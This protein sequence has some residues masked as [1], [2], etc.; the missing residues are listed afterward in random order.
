MDT[1]TSPLLSSPHLLLLNLLLANVDQTSP[2]RWQLCLQQ[3]LKGKVKQPAHLPAAEQHFS[4]GEPA[5]LKTASQMSVPSRCCTLI[6]VFQ[7][8]HFK[9]STDRPP[10]ERGLCSHQGE[11]TRPVEGS[12]PVSSSSADGERRPERSPEEGGHHPINGTSPLQPR[13]VCPGA[14]QTAG[15]PGS[16]SARGAGR[17]G[18]DV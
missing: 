10:L 4:P 3:S 17:L 9:T 7:N 6:Q 2:C 15:C 13:T 1:S 5:E 8:L 11:G 16:T 18:W 14:Q 12:E